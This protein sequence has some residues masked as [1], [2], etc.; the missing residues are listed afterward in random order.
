M[1]GEPGCLADR[2]V[3]V[4]LDDVL[5]GDVAHGIEVVDAE[6]AEDAAGSGDVRLGGRRG[7]VCRSRKGEQAAKRAG[8][9]RVTGGAVAGVEA[10]LEAD[11][12]E[13]ARARDLLQD[14]VDRREVERNG[15]LAERRD[16]CGGGK[17]EQ[18]RVPRGRRGDHEC[19]HAGIDERFGRLRCIRVE[20]L[21]DLEGAGRVGIGERERGDAVERPEALHVKGADPADTDHPDVEPLRHGSA[22]SKRLHKPLSRRYGGGAVELRT[23]RAGSSRCR[24]CRTLRP[25]AS[26]SRS[27]VASSAIS[28]A[29]WWIVVNGGLVNFE[30]LRSSNPTIETSSGTR[31][32]LSTIA[33]ITP[34][35]ERSFAANTPV[36]PG[37]SSSDRAAS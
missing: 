32:P 27:W 11:L 22:Y 20:I 33:L 10:A 9:D 26:S 25:L 12:H 35:A 6:V 7:V 31:R 29:G 19:V 14:V 34:I 28:N 2:A 21:R 30:S 24:S 8:S 3:G 23:T 13:D 1:L 17:P 15:L 16:P 5:P 36:K 4:H 18:R 37:V